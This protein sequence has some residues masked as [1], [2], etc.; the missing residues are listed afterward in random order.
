MIKK[1]LSICLSDPTYI[2]TKGWTRLYLHLNYRVIFPNHI[3]KIIL[4]PGPLKFTNFN[5]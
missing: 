5:I 4:T 2:S 1:A 3:N